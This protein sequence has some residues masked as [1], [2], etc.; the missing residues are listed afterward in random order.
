MNN[1]FPITHD[2][3]AN[4]FETT[5]NDTHCVL[6][7]VMHGNVMAITHTSVPPAVS[8][9]GIAAEMTR[10]ALAAARKSGFRVDPQCAYAAAYFAR[11]PADQ[12]L[13]A[14]G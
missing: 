9:R 11:H 7:Y 14:Q 13:L 4:R 10:V 2:E 6:D 12:D 8:G 1:E 3:A 5:V